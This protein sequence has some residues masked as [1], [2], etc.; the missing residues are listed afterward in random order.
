M[1]VCSILTNSPKNQVFFLCI[2]FFVLGSFIIENS[3]TSK[4]FISM[5]IL[6]YYWNKS[7]A[8]IV[9]LFLLLLNGTFYIDLYE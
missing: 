9:Q 7:S 4:F 5:M 8:R 3:L 1:S 6:N 2:D